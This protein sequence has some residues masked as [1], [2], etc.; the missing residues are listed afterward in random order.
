MPADDLARLTIDRTAAPLRRRTIRPG[1]LAAAAA[2]LVALG[3]GGY[4]LLHPVPQVAVATVSRVYPSQTFT[5]L[6]ASGYVVAQR[7]ASVASKG[8]GRLVWLGVEE[9]SAVKAGQVIARLES[10]D[11][12]AVTAQARAGLAAAR[13]NRETARAQRDAAAAARD[14]AGAQRQGARSTL[15]QAKAEIDDALTALE[16]ERALFAGGMSAKVSLDAAETRWRKAEAALAAAGHAAEAAGSAARAAADSFAAAES[17]L[18]SVGHAVASAE[19]V[20]RGAVVELLKGVEANVLLGNLKPLLAVDDAFAIISVLEVLSTVGKPEAAL[21]AEPFLEHWSEQVRRMAIRCVAANDSFRLPRDLAVLLH[22]RSPSVRIEAIRQAGAVGEK[23]MGESLLDCLDYD[24]DTRYF[25]VRALTQ[26]L[27]KEARDR[28]FQ[29]YPDVG[30]LVKLA[31]LEYAEAIGDNE[32]IEFLF[33][34]IDDK[35]GSAR[36]KA[37]RMLIDF[38]TPSLRLRLESLLNDHDERVRQC[39]RLALNS[40]GSPSEK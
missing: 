21:L 1:R 37:A 25:A 39:A 33:R 13:A 18:V 28:L 22:D 16:R 2:A 32:S 15:A 4:R 3:F 36:A 20:V 35:D 9:G 11:L 6:N 40:L 17:A 12:A 23:F 8:T 34:M 31:I 38:A 26:L 19:A 5:A 27:Y 10:D 29:M 24:D 30:R 14:S 7:K